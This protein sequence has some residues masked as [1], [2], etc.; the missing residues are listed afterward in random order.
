ML[1]CVVFT[2]AASPTG[3]GDPIEFVPATGSIVGGI[4][5]V[6]V[7]LH[8]G[9]R[10]I[11]FKLYSFDNFD[12]L[13]GQNGHTSGAAMSSPHVN[14]ASKWQANPEGLRKIWYCYSFQGFG[15]TS[16]QGFGRTI[17]L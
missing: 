2:Q 5:W 11:R 4:Y 1:C 10:Q 7:A 6:G 15:Q 3:S 9:V 13:P 17:V 8:S 12:V 14:T 16:F